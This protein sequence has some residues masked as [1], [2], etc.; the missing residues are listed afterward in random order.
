M[1]NLLMLSVLAA[2]S[3]HAAMIAKPIDYSVGEIHFQG[4]LVYDDAITAKRPGLVMI[5]NWYGI[6]AAAI[7]KAKMIAGKDYVIFL[8]DMYGKDIRPDGRETASAAVKPLYGDRSIMRTRVNAA[9][10][11]LKAQAGSA[12]IDLKHL[13][14]LGFCF[15]GSAALDLARSGADIQSV[16]TFHGGLA[17]D[18]PALAKNIKAHVLVLNGAD[19]KGVGPDVPAFE[20]EMRAANID[21]QLVNFG[22]AVHCFTE[23]GENSAGCKYDEKVSKRAYVMMRNWLTE[24]W[25]G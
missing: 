1:R 7:A 4:Q 16:V 25:R 3:A 6:N 14:A 20:D 22:G 24:S 17:T 10:D 15:G 21:W 5:P 18:D 11:Q 23:V 8:G 2:G 12:P 19:D 9:L 13:G